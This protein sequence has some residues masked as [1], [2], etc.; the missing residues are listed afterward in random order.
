MAL[1]ISQR[2]G[3]FK[4][5]QLQYSEYMDCVMLNLP[6]RPTFDG[7]K[8]K[9][10]QHSTVYDHKGLARNSEISKNLKNMLQMYILLSP[11]VVCYLEANSFGFYY[12]TAR[13][14]ITH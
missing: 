11:L 5:L 4:H 8:Y 13:Y 6:Y 9:Q 1:S 2:V 14:Q 12:H 7:L 3:C 10:L